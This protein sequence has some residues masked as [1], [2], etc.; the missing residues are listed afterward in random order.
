MLIGKFKS[1]QPLL[2][3]LLVV[4]AV[5]LWIDGFLQ[6]DQLGTD[7]SYGAPLYTPIAAFF[8]QYR[9]L[10]VLLSFVFMLVQAFMLNRIIAGKNLVERNSLLPALM[11]IVLMSSS[12]ALMGMHPVLFANFFLIIALDKIFDVFSEEDVF[13][14]IFNVGLFI[15]IAA[16]FFFPALWFILLIISALVIYYFVNVRGFLASIIGFFTPW[17]FLAVYYYWFDRLDEKFAEL[18][19]MQWSVLSFS[20]ELTPFGWTSLS[21][22][23]VISLVAVVRIFF[24]GM[25][26][27][28]IRIR[29][30]Y[31]VLLTSLGI[32]LLSVFLSGKPEPWHHGVILLPLSGILAG[33]F[34]ENKKK[35]WNELFFTLLIILIVL[36]KLTRLD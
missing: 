30:R 24:G 2:Y 27:K 23:G 4:I 3:G 36:G 15:S 33:F 14:E 18:S 8:D 25:L 6:Y 22:I 20:L 29:R 12:F 10:N 13:L 28:P 5:F 21:V 11:Y 32:A 7:T 9:L 35:F 26:D 17:M 34:Q 1:N 16:M 19:L 31:Q